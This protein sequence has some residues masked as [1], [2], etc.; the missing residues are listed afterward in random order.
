MENNINYSAL[1]FWKWSD[2]LVKNIEPL[3]SVSVLKKKVFYKITLD[4]LVQVFYK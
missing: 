2:N 1:L 4:F 3:H